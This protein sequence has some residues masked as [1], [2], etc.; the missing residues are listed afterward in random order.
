[1]TKMK[2][3]DRVIWMKYNYTGEIDSTG[4]GTVLKPAGEE[5]DFDIIILCD[6]G[7]IERFAS[8]MV[9]RFEDW[10]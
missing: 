5:N 4:F 10:D 9:K 2:V 6:G 3:N 8:S 7:T 1:M